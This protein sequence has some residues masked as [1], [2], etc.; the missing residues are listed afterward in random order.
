MSAV[1]PW[2]IRK[3]GNVGHSVA[4][5]CGWCRR[6]PD[7][8]AIALAEAVEIYEQLLPLRD[9]ETDPLGHA[10]LLANQANA[11]AHLGVFLHAREKFTQSRE[12]FLKGGDPESARAVEEQLEAL[13]VEKE[14]RLG[15]L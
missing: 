8:L 12:F 9:P 4:I 7:A 11:L 15:A 3:G 14:S 2:A 13:P 1:R 5:E 6:A 10:R